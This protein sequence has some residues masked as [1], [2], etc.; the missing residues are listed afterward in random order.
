MQ[1]EP[2]TI[3]SDG[4]TAVM[5]SDA[6][7][8]SGTGFDDS[9][10]FS[11]SGCEH[12]ADALAATV[13]RASLDDAEVRFAPL[14]NLTGDPLF[15]PIVR[16]DTAELY[17]TDE[18][19]GFWELRE[20][21][22]PLHVDSDLGMV[23]EAFGADL[24]GDGDSDVIARIATSDKGLQTSVIHIW[25]RDG[26][27]LRDSTDITPQTDSGGAELT[28]ADVDGDGHLDLVSIEVWDTIVY[29]GDGAFHFERINAGRLIDSA[30][31]TRARWLRVADA[32]ADGDPDLLAILNQVSGSGTG[33]HA[34]AALLPGD[35]HGGFDTAIVVDMGLAAGLGSGGG[36]ADLDGDARLDA[37]TYGKAF[38]GS[39]MSELRVARQLAD[40]SFG[41]ATVAYTT[42]ATMVAAGAVHDA[43]TGADRLQLVAGDELI[44]LAF[45]ADSDAPASHVQRI[46]AGEPNAAL[47]TEPSDDA[48]TELVV[49][50]ASQCR[51]G[52][53]P[54]IECIDDDECGNQHCRAGQCGAC[55]SSDEC[56]EDEICEQRC[57]HAVSAQD[58]WSALA[59]A[60]D[61]G[62]GITTAGALRCWG[63]EDWGP[64]P[65]GTFTALA[66]TERDTESHRGVGCAIQ[67]NGELACWP[68]LRDADVPAPP[69]GR[70]VALDADASRLCA[71]AQDGHAVCW[72]ADAT[73]E[74]QPPDGEY[75]AVSVGGGHTCL[76][77]TEGELRCFGCD[78]PR[79][80]PYSDSTTIS[81]EDESAGCRSDYGQAHPPSGRFD[82]VA[83]GGAHTCAI[84]HESGA[85]VCFG[86][87][88]DGQAHPPKGSYRAVAADTSDT[89]AIADDGHI[90]CFGQQGEWSGH[91]TEFS[92]LAMF[93]YRTCALRSDGRVE[94]LAGGGP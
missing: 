37:F 51:C 30:L 64:L 18:N 50:I 73:D 72:N 35:G 55:I 62:C 11:G 36:F 25:E 70:F 44:S 59:I 85:L 42:K 90:E 15:Q 39:P 83:A 91:E 20:G 58:D 9:G 45:S 12:T 86:R 10:Y 32:N 14:A 61:G 80:D 29:R 22:M 13:L 69:S 74:E 56:A 89:C 26:D 38:E 84:E 28:V 6:E 4:H 19:G 3:G 52:S 43:K 47:F 60:T 75:T 78:G 31:N 92:A 77:T 63:E 5:G 82:A 79:Q 33:P 67:D 17:V 71:I 1:R 21:G 34:F 81:Q 40:A 48:V 68:A 24:D 54:M 94:C 88:I 87:D 57:I 27:Q 66:V 65:D 49:L 53:C 46:A 16:G 93:G 41:Q 23:M 7:P 76:L 8:T 2:H